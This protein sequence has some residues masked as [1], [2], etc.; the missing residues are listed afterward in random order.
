LFGCV[1]LLHVLST[2]KLDRLICKLLCIVADGSVL[3]T[4]SLRP[5]VMYGELDPYYVTSG[6]T[7]AK[8]NNGTLLR[9]GSG[10]AKFQQVRT[11][12]FQEL[13]I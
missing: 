5:N 1:A 2:E 10:T 4:L 8:R 9:I 11:N 13:L 6:L 3:H 7:A 12:S